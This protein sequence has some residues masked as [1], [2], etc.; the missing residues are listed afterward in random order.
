MAV[1]QDGVGWSRGLT[2]T[3]C[4]YAESIDLQH[5]LSLFRNIFKRPN[6]KKGFLNKFK[7]CLTKCTKMAKKKLMYP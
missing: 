5:N 7:P 2:F 6:K 4:S 3:S 1:F